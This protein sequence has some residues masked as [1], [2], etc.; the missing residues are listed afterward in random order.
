MICL[1]LWNRAWLDTVKTL[2]NND[3]KFLENVK[4]GYLKEQFL[5][6]NI[7]LKKQDK[8][9]KKIFRSSDLFDI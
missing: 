2:C 1:K 4:Q 5:A 6:T 7:D 9:E 8:Q 3:I